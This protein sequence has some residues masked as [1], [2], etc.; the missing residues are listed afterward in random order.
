MREL[1]LKNILKIGDKEFLVSTISMHV[2]HSFFDGDS[3]RLVYETMVFEIINDEVQFHHSIFNERYNMAD[4]AIA[5][6]GAIIKNPKNFFI[7]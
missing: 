5:E 7:I 2:R 1:E 4:E 3:K 6:H